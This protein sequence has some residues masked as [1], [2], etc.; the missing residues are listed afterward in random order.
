[1]LKRCRQAQINRIPLLRTAIV[2]LLR[3]ESPSCI[4]VRLTNHITDKL[5]FSQPFDLT[6]RCLP[7]GDDLKRDEYCLAPIDDKTYARCRVLCIEGALVKVFFIDE[8]ISAWLSKDCL[9]TMP[10][11]LAYHPWQAIK[12]SLCGVTMRKSS[13]YGAK[14]SLM[15]SEEECISFRQLLSAFPLLKTRTVKSSIIHN[16]NRRPVQV[17]LL[18]FDA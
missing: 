5:V 6:Q 9:A 13:Y 14:S 17:W 18:G 10:T 4:W 8:G 15:W 11:E 2:H 16:D 12:V 3:A 7:G 1:M